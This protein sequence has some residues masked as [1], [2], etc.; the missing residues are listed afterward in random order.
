[1]TL[2]ASD[3]KEQ[4]LG[5]GST[6]VFGFPHLFFTNSDIKV[7]ELNISTGIETEIVSGI[8]INGAGV[9]AGAASAAS[10]VISAVASG[11]ECA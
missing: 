5:N 8:T 1:M 3:P 4:Y 10:G 9:E 6:T 11:V 7:T 2:P